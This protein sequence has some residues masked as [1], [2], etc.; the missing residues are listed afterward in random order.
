[1]NTSV[2]LIICAILFGSYDLA[3][4][5]TSGSGNPT[6]RALIVQ[7]FS[8][9]TLALLTLFEPLAQSLIFTPNLLYAG[10]AGI[11]M[12]FALNLLFSLLKNSGLQTSSI[13]PFALIG[14]NLVL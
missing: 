6:A 10:I 5:L 7:I 14:R 8:V 13:L 11:L 2:L 9:L 12:G 4:K 1:M 3:I